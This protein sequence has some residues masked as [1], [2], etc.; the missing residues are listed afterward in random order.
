MLL[1]CH[2]RTFHILTNKCVFD[3]SVFQSQLAEEITFE[4]LKK[5]IGEI[6]EKFLR[7]HNSSS[8]P[9]RYFLWTCWSVSLHANTIYDLAF[10]QELHRPS[11]SLT[12]SQ[13][14][15]SN[16]PWNI[17]IY[18]LSWHAWHNDIDIIVKV[19][20]HLTRGW[21]QEL[22]FYFQIYFDCSVHEKTTSAMSH[23]YHYKVNLKV[24]KVKQKAVRKRWNQTF[25]WHI[26]PLRLFSDTTGLEEQEREKR[27]QVMEKFQKAPFE[28]IAAHC[29]SKVRNKERKKRG[30]LPECSGVN[31]HC[32]KLPVLLQA[33]MLHDRLAQIFELT[34]R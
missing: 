23:Y 12:S 8:K 5:A 31:S 29:E 13:N 6:K 15:D 11:A 28:E 14:L 3:P 25:F 33:N 21:L 1:Y 26:I 18:W 30:K 7:L 19:N 22:I 9:P 32:L 34:I 24:I 10:C 17:K 2:M 16:V 27:R 4:T 20:I